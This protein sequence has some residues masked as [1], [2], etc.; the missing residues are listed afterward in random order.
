[1]PKLIVSYR[2]SDSTAIAGRICDRLVARYGHDVVFLD[3]DSIRFATDVRGHIR[4]SISRA[5]VM[6]VVIG[7]GWL[8][9]VKSRIH[10][11]DDPVRAELERAINPRGS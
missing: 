7:P 3:V 5:D 11:D 9:P 6:L 1:M 8:G 2:R 10:A 4:D